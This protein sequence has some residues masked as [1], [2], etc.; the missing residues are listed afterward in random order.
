ME[1]L[2]FLVFMVLLLVTISWGLHRY[3]PPSYFDPWRKKGG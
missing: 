2:A 3:G 1:A